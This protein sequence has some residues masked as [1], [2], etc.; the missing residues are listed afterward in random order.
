MGRYAAFAV[1]L[2]IYLAG[3]IVLGLVGVRALRQKRSILAVGFATSLVAWLVVQ[4]A[5]FLVAR[6]C[7]ESGTTAA[8]AIL[9]FP[10]HVLGYGLVASLLA[11][12]VQE[13]ARYAVF[14]SFA[15]FRDNR[16]WRAS[17]TYTLGHHGMEMMAVG[18]S[19]VLMFLLLRYKPDLFSPDVAQQ[20]GDAFAINS[21]TEVYNAFEWLSVGL[22]VQACFSGVVML[23]VVRRNIGWLLL[24]IAWHVAHG[25][26]GLSLHGISEHWLVS[27]A[28]VAIIIVGYSYLAVRI[29]R[30]LPR[31]EEAMTGAGS[32]RPPMILPGREQA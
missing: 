3:P 18:L 2:L 14:R 10:P 15:G 5:M 25:V 17:L 7:V 29:Y 27:K 16:N 26:V 19:V 23:A 8:T 28:W 11:A 1:E 30:A 32:G 6:W 22:L 21:G 12:L 24:A 9:G 13:P 4:F 31:R 20:I